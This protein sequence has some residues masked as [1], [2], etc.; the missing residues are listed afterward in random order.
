MTSGN[1]SCICSTTQCCQVACTLVTRVLSLSIFTYIYI[2]V[3]SLGGLFSIKLSKKQ[4]CSQNMAMKKNHLKGGGFSF[5]N[6]FS[7]LSNLLFS[8]L[9]LLFTLCLS[10]ILKSKS[11]PPKEV[12]G[13]IHIY[14]YIF[15]ICQFPSL[16]F[17]KRKKEENDQLENPEAIDPINL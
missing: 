4:F 14:I 9:V 1:I 12:T 10:S 16:W 6:L 15:L 11:Y 13:Y 2:V 8:A 3:T 17:R 5:V 7:S